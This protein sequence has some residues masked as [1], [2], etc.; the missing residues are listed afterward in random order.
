MTP[1]FVLKNVVDTGNSKILK[2]EHLKLNIKQG[3]SAPINGIAFGMAS[4]Y[5]KI[6]TGQE[7]DVCFTLEL[8][9]FRGQANLQLMVKDIR[10]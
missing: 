2:G 1:T 10:V 5:E 3:D 8:N 9:E 7:F 6:Q 4:Y